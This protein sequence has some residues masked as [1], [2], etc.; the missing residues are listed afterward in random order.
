MGR[1]KK[2]SLH[3]LSLAFREIWDFDK[4]FLF[5]LFA[6]V[7]VSAVR[8]F[9]GILLAG[10]IVDCISEGNAF[11]QVI[12]YVALL[13]GTEYSLTAVSTFLAK[14]RDYLIIRI[15]N[16]LD[17]EINRKCMNM[18]LEKFNDASVRERIQMV[19]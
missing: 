12:F 3:N 18:D 5:L 4:S 1:I 6:D 9:P 11:S 15:T 2:G 19:N 13:Y 7:F 14:S 16:Q 17:N 8:P 10:R